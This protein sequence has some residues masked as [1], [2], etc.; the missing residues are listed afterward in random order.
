MASKQHDEGS[1]AGNRFTGQA[2]LGSKTVATGFKIFYYTTT[3]QPN[4]IKI[5]NGFQLKG[6][7]VTKRHHQVTNKQGTAPE[8]RHAPRTVLDLL[9][10][11]C[12]LQSTAKARP[13]LD[14]P[15]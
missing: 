8:H 13:S 14:Q 12:S 9:A 15:R 7:Q 6:I 11:V 10:P 4:T 5:S 3:T 1:H 2:P